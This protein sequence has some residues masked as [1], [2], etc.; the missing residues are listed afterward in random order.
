MLISSF[1]FAIDGALAKILSQSIASIEVVFFRNGVTMLLVLFSLARTPPKH[2]GGKPWLLLFRALI[3]FSAMLAF[4]YNIAHI[5]L[6]DAMTFSRT[7]PIFYSDVGIFLFERADGVAWMV[8]CSFRVY[9][10]CFGD[11]A[12]WF[13]ALKNRY[14]WAFK[15]S[16]R[17][18]GVYQCTR[19]P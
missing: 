16:W 9:R 14:F 17:S 4:F 5:P 13:D 8:C 12:Q 2:K 7:A 19:T 10:H 6:A 18:V 1:S 15:R 11:E 3:G